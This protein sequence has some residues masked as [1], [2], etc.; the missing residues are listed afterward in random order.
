MSEHQDLVGAALGALARAYAPYSKFRVGAALE[1]AG[2]RIYAGA[3]VE[4]SSYGL[5]ICAERA[6]VCAAVA[7]G[8]REFVRIA[9]VTSRGEATAPCGACRQVL[10]EFAPD[11]EVLLVARKRVKRVRLGEIF[12]LAF[13]LR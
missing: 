8:D 5:S 4:N 7:A 12:P 1:T 11:L 10:A 9:V 2:G 13:R 3:N 6:A